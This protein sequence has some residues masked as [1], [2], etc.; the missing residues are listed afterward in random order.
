MNTGLVYAGGVGP[1]DAGDYSVM[2]DAVNVAA[3]LKERPS[4]ARSWWDPTPTARPSTSSTWQTAGRTQVKGKADPVPP[5][6][7]SRPPGAVGPGRRR[8]PR[9]LLP[10]RRPGERT[11][12]LRGASLACARAR[13]GS[14]SSPARPAWGSPGWSPRRGPGREGE[15]LLA[16]RPHPLLRPHHQLL[17]AARDH[18]A[19]RRHRERR[20]RE[21]SAGP[22]WPRGWGRSSARSDSE[23]LP[24]LAT[25]LSLS[26]PEDLAPE[27]EV[28]RRR[29]HGPPDLPGDPP[30]LRP[31]RPGAAHGGGLRG[32]PLAGRLLSRLLLEHLLPLTGEVPILF[33]LVSRPEPDSALTRLRELVHSEYADRL[34]EIALKPL[35]A[36]ESATLVRN[37][38][39]PGRASGPPRIPSSGRPR[40]TP[41]SWKRWSA[42]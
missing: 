14:S 38:V 10:A 15:D 1:A 5:T 25:L 13:A 33:F 16:G 22:S 31:P 34:T 6:G 19:G 37:L 36:E 4:Q 40:A 27:G 41:S 23:I 9:P 26:L 7:S 11:R 17:A 18:P 30:L 3:R 21:R 42:A 32:R 29:G 8:S 24:Y 28:P 2:G 12:R 35:S 20:P 39:A